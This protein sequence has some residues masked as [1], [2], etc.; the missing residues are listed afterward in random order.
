MVHFF[1]PAEVARRMGVSRS[2]VLWWTDTHK[3][4]ALRTATGRRLIPAR[5]LQKFTEDRARK[6]QAHAGL[7]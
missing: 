7:R 1:T 2:T 4:K 6:T 5:S 3:L